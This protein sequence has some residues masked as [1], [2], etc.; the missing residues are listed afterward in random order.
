L[1]GI[2][3]HALTLAA[4]KID[5]DNQKVKE[6]DNVELKIYS[7]SG[8][9]LSPDTTNFEV[10]YDDSVFA[11]VSYEGIGDTKFDQKEKYVYVNE[12]ADLTSINDDQLIGTLTLKVKENVN[13]TASTISYKTYYEEVINSDTLEFTIS[14]KDNTNNNTTNNNTTNNNVKN[15]NTTDNS[16]QDSNNLS[17]SEIILI[18]IASVISI[19]II[20]SIIIM[21]RKNKKAL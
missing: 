11:F 9:K 6:G 16:T 19:F 4:F 2:G 20:V 18:Y 5:V 13:T 7:I 15:N 17:T 10:K 3:A 14:K 8:G 1:F 21:L 12:A